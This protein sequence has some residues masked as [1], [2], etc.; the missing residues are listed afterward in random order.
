M[1]YNFIQNLFYCKTERI[2]GRGTAASGS[3]GTEVMITLTEKTRLH[4]LNPHNQS[5]TLESLESG[6]LH[7][8]AEKPHLGYTNT[9]STMTHPLQMPQVIPHLYRRLCYI[10]A[11]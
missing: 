6:N 3:N 4:A 8:P 5:T 11:N 2:D 1:N 9:I 10:M 7:L